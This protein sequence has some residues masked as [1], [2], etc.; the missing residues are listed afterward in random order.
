[1]QGAFNDFSVRVREG[2]LRSVQ[3]EL[4]RLLEP[5][6]VHSIIRR[7]EQ[8][9][10]RF[11]ED[12]IRQ[13]KISAV[14]FP[15]IFLLIA[16][17]LIH[18]MT[19]RLVALHRSQ[20]GTLKAMGYSDQEVG[21]H[22]LI[23]SMML[24]LLGL[25]PGLLMGWGVGR[26]MSHS[27]E[28]FF[29]FPDL[30]FSISPLAA[31]I[32]VLAGWASGLLG[33]LMSVRRATQMT[34]SEAM[35]PL[36][37]TYFRG[38]GDHW[39]KGLSP[40]LLMLIRHSVGNPVRFSLTLAGLSCAIALLVLSRS[41]NDMITQLLRTQF[42]L[43]QKEVIMVNFV[44][45]FSQNALQ[46]LRSYPGVLE[47]E[48]IRTIPIRIRYQHRS[49]N[50]VLQ[51]WDDS[52]HLREFPRLEMEVAGESG[53][54]PRSLL[55]QG[56]VLSR[57]LGE[58][59]GLHPG[60][61]LEWEMLDG[62]KKKFRMPVAGFSDDR[63]GRSA[64]LST[65]QIH[66][67]LSE[68]PRWNQALLRIDSQRKT[69]LYSRLKNLP[70][71]ASVFLKGELVRGFR[72]TIAAMIRV[73]TWVL[74][75][76]AL[77]ITFGMITNSVRVSFSERTWELSSLRVLGFS[78]SEVFVLFWKEILFQLILSLLPGCV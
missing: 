45:P 48:G 5:Y 75:G 57:P 78:F 71:V 30:A 52:I 49:K 68:S 36:A 40:R 72:E 62:E 19:S 18:V 2:N 13:Q 29:R 1:M 4:Q 63:I 31:V 14:F 8:I 64:A 76:F 12:E 67:L 44:A 26:W 42:S 47:V 27:Y 39:L 43:I 3:A 7:D 34:P 51:G 54:N 53:E 23:F 74:T 17:F 33:G 38:E 21:A 15:A 20:I 50:L 41:W 25:L 16:A 60:D 55:E 56:I 11:V 22:Y 46:E 24:P 77:G 9:S 65:G 66:R 69:E 37:P 73:S 59:W 58:D 6:G 61:L 28:Q 32:G 70:W 35:R 10:N